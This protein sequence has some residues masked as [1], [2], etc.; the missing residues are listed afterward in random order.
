[1]PTRLSAF[2]QALVLACPSAGPWALVG[3]YAQRMFAELLAELGHRLIIHRH[4]DRFAAL[5]FVGIN[6]WRAALHI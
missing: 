3:E 1:M 4:A 5:R 6:P 2:L